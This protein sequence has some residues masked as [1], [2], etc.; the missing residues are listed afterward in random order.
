MPHSVI[1][2]QKE[3]NLKA[4]FRKYERGLFCYTPHPPLPLKGEGLACL[5][6]GRGGGGLTL[7]I[8]V[9]FDLM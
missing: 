9:V 2:R 1:D 5:P 3:P 4:L 7:F 8:L 6:V